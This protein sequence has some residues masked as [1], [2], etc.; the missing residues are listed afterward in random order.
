[1][2]LHQ[3]PFMWV[4]SLS[5]LTR[6]ALFQDS[7]AIECFSRMKLPNFSLELFVYQ[8]VNLQGFTVRCNSS[9]GSLPL[10]RRCLV[11]KVLFR[12]FIDWLFAAVVF[13][14]CKTNFPW[15]CYFAERLS[16]N[17]ARMTKCSW[18][19]HCF[20]CESKLNFFVLVVTLP[21]CLLCSWLESFAQ[22]AT[23]LGKNIWLVHF[24]HFYLTNYNCSGSTSIST[25]ATMYRL[26]CVLLANDY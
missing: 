20:W 7:L 4:H 25:N 26:D 1:M 3:L 15:S 2:L 19:W 10:K 17:E 11:L 9:R 24:A 12:W 23:F 16:S 8:I 18:I 13:N 14:F 21:D 6:A 22:L 5:L